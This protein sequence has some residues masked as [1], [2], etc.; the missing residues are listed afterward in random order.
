M[1][2]GLQGEVCLGCGVPA[3]GHNPAG[4]GLWQRVGAPWRL[5][6]P[7]VRRS[8]TP[9][10]PVPGQRAEGARGVPSIASG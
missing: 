8:T 10:A 5:D 6:R 4:V 7:V 9:I 3:G 1:S 2:G